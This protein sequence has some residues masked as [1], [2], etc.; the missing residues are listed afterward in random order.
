[1]TDDRKYDSAGQPLTTDPAGPDPGNT[2]PDKLTAPLDGDDDVYALLHQ[3][4]GDLR[5]T[6]P[7]GEDGPTK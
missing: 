2:D 5:E 1:M 7:V 3:D 6:T 4:Q